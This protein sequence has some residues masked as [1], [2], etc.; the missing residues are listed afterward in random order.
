MIVGIDEIS[1]FKI[2]SVFLKKLKISSLKNTRTAKKDPMCKLTS[3]ER[4]WFEL[5]ESRE[6]LCKEPATIRKK[7]TKDYWMWE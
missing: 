1:I 7:I 4:F 2:R 5:V 3:M 6:K